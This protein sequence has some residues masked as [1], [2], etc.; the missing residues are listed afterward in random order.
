MSRILGTAII[1]LFVVVCGIALI[2]TFS[3]GAVEL[4]LLDPEQSS[5]PKV[6]E[7]FRIMKLT[8]TLASEYSGD[9]ISC[10][11]CHFNGGNSQGGRNNGISLVGVSYEY[12]RFSK[13]SGS[14]IDLSQRIS[15]CFE[16]SLNGKPVP[17]N[18]SIMESLVAYLNW[19]S[20]PAEGIND[21]SWLG[22]KP[23][24]TKH[25]PNY[26]KGKKQYEL[27]CALCHKTDGGGSREIEGD[28]IPPIFGD[29]SF[30]DGAG[31]NNPATFASFI[32]LN[33][34]QD[35]PYLTE[36][37]AIDIAEYVTK[38]PRPRFRQEQ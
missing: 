31:M 3:R 13:R 30:N 38:Q 16:R 9:L 37:Q 1:F 25:I 32:Y 27:H 15:N 35:D 12:P 28:N 24:S 5:D 2:V 34:P 20:K 8:P 10:N 21:R 14:S 6:M 4:E 11:N 26:E 22:L 19:I 29:Q 18:D 17:A 33:M 7:G 23:L 36:E